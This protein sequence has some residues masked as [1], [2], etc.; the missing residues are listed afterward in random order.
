M[1]MK[2]FYIKRVSDF[3]TIVHRPTHQIIMMGNMDEEMGKK[4][5]RFIKMSTEEFYK[6]L[7]SLG[8]KFKTSRDIQEEQDKEKEDW[9]K[10]AWL[11]TTKQVLNHYK[12]KEDSIPEEEV[13]LELIEELQ[14]REGTS[15]NIELNKEAKEAPEKKEKPKKL[16][17]KKKLPKKVSNEK[18]TTLVPYK[19]KQEVRRA[20]IAGEID[21]ETLKKYMRAL[22]S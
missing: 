6:E 7:N 22:K 18:V 10:G 9:Y 21:I 4:I 8:L 19:S 17:K 2:R 16:L 12:I 20:Y 5:K 13:P 14:R 15:W 11:Y 1:V 3:V